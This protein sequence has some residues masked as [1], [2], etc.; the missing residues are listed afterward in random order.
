MHAPCVRSKSCQDDKVKVEVNVLISLSN[1]PSSVRSIGS[2]KD[3]NN[4]RQLCHRLNSTFLRH[5]MF[6]PLK[7]DIDF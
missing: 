5:L 4:V 7:S 3:F 2:W 6:V 1:I